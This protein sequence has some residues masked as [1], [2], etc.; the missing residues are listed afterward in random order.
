M[1]EVQN[2]SASKKS[3]YCSQGDMDKEQ[4]LNDSTSGRQ[5]TSSLQVLHDGV[6][7]CGFQALSSRLSQQRGQ[8]PVYASSIVM[9]LRCRNNMQS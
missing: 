1:H 9:T 3:I 7:I 6:E 8:P 5:A 2:N 4:A